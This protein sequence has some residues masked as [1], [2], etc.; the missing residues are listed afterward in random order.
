MLVKNLTGVGY[1]GRFPVHESARHRQP[2]QFRPSPGIAEFAQPPVVIFESLLVRDRLFEV[3]V[4]R[5]NQCA[6]WFCKRRPIESGVYC[7]QIRPALGAAGVQ[8]QLGQIGEQLAQCSP[9][10]VVIFSSSQGP[11]QERQARTPIQL[12]FRT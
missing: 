8:L 4:R 9:S 5:L 10:A 6:D 3:L 7:D 12:V 2:L 11:G 1:F